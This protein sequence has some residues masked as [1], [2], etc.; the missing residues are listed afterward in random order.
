M[1]ALYAAERVCV[2]DEGPRSRPCAVFTRHFE[3]DSSVG[4][5]TRRSAAEPARGKAIRYMGDLWPGLVRFINE[6]RL[7]L[8]NNATKRALRGVVQLH[9]GDRRDV[10]LDRTR[11]AVP[12]S[13]ARPVLA[14]RGGLG[15]EPNN[16]TE[17]ALAALHNA[18]ES[19]QRP[20]G[21]VHHSNRGSPYA[22][23]DYRR[24]L[25]GLGIA[26]MSR[27]G[28]CWDNAGAESF[29][30]SIKSELVDDANYDSQASATASIAEYIEKFY[31]PVRRHSY[32]G[33][34]SPIEFELKTKAAALAA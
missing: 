11:L 20:P 23:G 5:P 19:R 17:L 30:S 14:P 2:G 34:N 31:N 8:D 21:L 7:A 18:T 27:K 4:A 15:D 25:L 28:D 12:R 16:N 13:D 9:L 33:Y 22:S 26:S 3:A 32:L 10:R 29:F 6:P 24:Q 1:R